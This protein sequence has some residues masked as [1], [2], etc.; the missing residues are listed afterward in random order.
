MDLSRFLERENTMRGHAVTTAIDRN[1]HVA[2]AVRGNGAL[3]SEFRIDLLT[4]GHGVYGLG[5]SM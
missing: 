1:R 5:P 3:A 2:F 4:V